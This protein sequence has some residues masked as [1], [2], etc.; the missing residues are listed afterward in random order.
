[1]TRGSFLAPVVWS[2]CLVNISSFSSVLITDDGFC[3]SGEA[4]LGVDFPL[5]P[6]SC[7]LSRSFIESGGA[8]DEYF[9]ADFAPS[10]ALSNAMARS[11]H[12]GRGAVFDCLPPRRFLI[13]FSTYRNTFNSPAR[14]EQPT[15]THVIQ[16]I[17]RPPVTGN[18]RLY[19]REPCNVC[20]GTT[21]E[22]SVAVSTCPKWSA[23]ARVGCT[24]AWRYPR[25]G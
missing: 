8:G 17:R 25:E 6:P 12:G 15:S 2:S 9:G 23:N 1:M 3:L 22:C 10:M 19:I 13:P 20:N 14:T 11:N 21:D 7:L 16:G 18:L 5:A 4:S 24:G